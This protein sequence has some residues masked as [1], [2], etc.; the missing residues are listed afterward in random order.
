MS[1]LTGYAAS[2]HRP[3][4]TY[5]CSYLPRQIP[6]F[7]RTLVPLALSSSPDFSF[8]LCLASGFC[9]PQFSTY[10]PLANKKQYPSK[11]ECSPRVEKFNRG[12]IQPS[13]STY[14]GL[15][16]HLC[17]AWGWQRHTESPYCCGIQNVYNYYCV[18]FILGTLHL[19]TLLN[20]YPTRR[21]T[22]NDSTCNVGRCHFRY[23]LEFSSWT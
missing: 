6:Q 22:E 3:L 17:R 18:S 11:S 23:V 19:W 21:I 16:D 12:R 1:L 15:C 5:P 14:T 7:L 8:V 4:G 9:L 20:E 2:I 13:L 10:S